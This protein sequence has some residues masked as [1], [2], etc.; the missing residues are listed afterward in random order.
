MAVHLTSEDR[1][2]IEKHRADN[3]LMRAIVR[4]L[5]RSPSSISRELGSNTLAE[6]KRLNS[7]DAAD[8]VAKKRRAAASKSKA[9]KSI[10]SFVYGYLRYSLNHHTSPIKN[11]AYSKDSTT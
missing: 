4:E 8:K 10:D 9:F 11:R 6:F 3:V 5:E 2:Y 7:A 1:I